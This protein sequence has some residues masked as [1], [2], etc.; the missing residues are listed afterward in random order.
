MLERVVA[1]YASVR[2]LSAGSHSLG[3]CPNAQHLSKVTARRVLPSTAL[4]AVA[5]PRIGPTPPTVP[6]RVTRPAGEVRT[7]AG[8]PVAGRPAAAS[9]VACAEGVCV[10]HLH[11]VAHDRAPRPERRGAGAEPPRASRSLP[12]PRLGRPERRREGVV[13]PVGLLRRVGLVQRERGQS[14]KVA[15][16]R[17]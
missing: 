4:R 17:D 9:R 14:R 1:W 15:L 16:A 11:R 3:T 5:G 12:L 8:Q 7:A 10:V 13:R 6:P 2:S